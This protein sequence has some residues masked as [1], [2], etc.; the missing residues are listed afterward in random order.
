MT[1]NKQ[2]IFISFY[3]YDCD[4]PE[5]IAFDTFEAAQREAKKDIRKAVSDKKEG[6]EYLDA[7][8]MDGHVSINKIV[9]FAGTIEYRRSLPAPENWIL[10]IEKN[11]DALSDDDAVA[12]TELFESFEAAE[13]ALKLHIRDEIRRVNLT[14]EEIS[15]NEW[16]RPISTTGEGKTRQLLWKSTYLNMRYS[17]Y[18][19]EYSR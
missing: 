18:R 1:K 19:L 9:I 3:Q 5:I 16:D 17:V 8:D 7:F 6:K 11:V 13:N 12:D 14:P 2:E 15:R 4:D 10:L